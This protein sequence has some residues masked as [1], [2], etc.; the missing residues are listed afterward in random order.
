MVSRHRL[1]LGQFLLAPIGAA[2]KAGM[3]SGSRT[4]ACAV[5]FGFSGVSLS[6]VEAAGKA[7]AES[8]IHQYVRPEA[9]QRIE[10][11]K[12]QGDKV[13]VVSG[14]LDIYLRPWCDAQKLELICSSLEHSDS[15]LTGR[16]RGLECI[17][18]EKSRRIREAYGLEG[19]ST[20]YA[21]GDSKDDNEML[22]LADKRYFQ[23]REMP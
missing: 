3:I 2:Y 12:A 4:R 20:V 16:Y 19:Y 14:G 8:G 17:G 7:F 6:Q 18:K 5:W 10:W 13:V 9:L 21:Y 15:V 11:H 23:W 1:R 22:Q